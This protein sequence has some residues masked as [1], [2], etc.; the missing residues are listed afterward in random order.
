MPKH[1]VFYLKPRYAVLYSPE[2]KPTVSE[3]DVKDRVKEILAEKNIV[4]GPNVDL[5]KHK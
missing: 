2:Y 1:S 5:S 4:L 3:E